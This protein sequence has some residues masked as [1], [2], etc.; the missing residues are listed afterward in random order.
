MVFHVEQANE[1]HKPQANS[2]KAQPTGHKANIRI[3]EWQ[4]RNREFLS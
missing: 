2:H 3:G 1:S 4:D